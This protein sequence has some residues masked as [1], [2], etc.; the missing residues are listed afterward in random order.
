MRATRWIRQFH[1]WT[2]VVFFLCVIATT[3]A[4]A[5]E[6]PLLWM[7]YLPLAPLALLALTGLY[8]FALPYLPQRDLP[9][10]ENLRD[11]APR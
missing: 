2:S 7:S 8:L 5:Q 4:L 6:R 9:Q 10:R 3:I 1:R 11:E